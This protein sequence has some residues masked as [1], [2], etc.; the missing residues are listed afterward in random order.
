QK[1]I[2]FMYENR[3]EKRQL[4]SRYL[5]FSKEFALPRMVDAMEEMLNA[6]VEDIKEGKD[7]PT[8]YPRKKDK[9]L[10]TKIFKKLFKK[11]IVKELPEYCK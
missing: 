5:E 11:G 2:D 3:Q 6:A 9:K 7:F 8:L 10:A 1:A 4:S